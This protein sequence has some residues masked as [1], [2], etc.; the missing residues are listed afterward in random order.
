[1]RELQRPIGRVWRRLRVQRFL[2]AAV[3]CW[4]AT[5]A[6]TAVAIA[7]ERLLHHPLSG[8]DWIPFT[9][10]GI[11]GMLVAALI[12]TV[13]GPSR[14]DAAVAIDQAF[15]LNERLSTALT[16]PEHLRETAAGRALLADAVEHVA[17]LDVAAP[18]HPRFPRTAWVPVI[19][20]VL[21]VALLFVPEWARR[22]ASARSSSTIEDEVVVHQTKALGAKIAGQRKVL[23]KSKFAEADKILA[24][25]EKVA[26]DL[27]KAPPAR[28][29]KALV[30]LNKLTDALKERQKQLGSPEQINR[31][32]QQ[33]RQMAST[34][35]AD[36]FA[37][38][39]A[40]GDFPKAAEEL[41]KLQEELLSGK[42]TE[43]N[44]VALQEQLAEMD[45]Q[46]RKLADFDR[47]RK[48]LEEACK[49]GGLSKDELDAQ[50]AKLDEQAKNM[51]QLQR[52]A[53]KLGQAEQD[54]T[55]NDLKKAAESL[56][57]SQ[58]Q[59]TELAKQLQELQALDGALAD[60]QDAK[61]GMTGDEMSRLGEGPGNMGMG[62]ENRKHG[63]NG[64]S[65]GR[66]RGDRPEA[67]GAT[68]TY[69]AK[70]KQ[71]FKKGRA[72]LEGHSPFNI[73]MKGRSVIDIQ[74]ELAT[75][76][77][78]S[79]DALT[80]QKIPRNLEKHIRGYFDQINK[81]K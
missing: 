42:M 59:L 31:Q 49:N 15:H 71:Q 55:R 81:G 63:Q 7:V 67:P 5:L 53:S 22:R 27:A 47:R 12:A 38:G 34:G 16:L 33:L 43:A 26:D 8:A 39:M 68:A 29:D 18:F 11:V 54:L 21:A 24:E 35:P 75:S 4:A 13:G 64:L 10:A 66:G 1:M 23:D 6:L 50:M 41:K 14:V 17:A 30:A 40:K 44:K 58:Q 20:A 57:M 3:W 45:K 19:P 48:Q 73:P 52:L 60:L 37:H 65:R 46:L 80:N 79:A 25:I 56:G 77:G 62:G 28:K 78:L 2:V 51:Q 70:V 61:D 36:E 74:G 9:V 76:E 69:N 32:L 72:V